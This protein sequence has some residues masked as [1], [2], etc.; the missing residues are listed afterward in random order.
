MLCTN[1]ASERSANFLAMSLQ[2]KKAKKPMTGAQ[3]QKAGQSEGGTARRGKTFGPNKKKRSDAGTT[4]VRKK[5]SDAGITRGPNRN[6]RSDA[7][8]TRGPNKRT[9]KKELLAAQ[10]RA[11]NNS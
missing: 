9:T 7:D 4:R 5:R 1:C 10:A 8:I 3:R 2:L 6:K 11:N